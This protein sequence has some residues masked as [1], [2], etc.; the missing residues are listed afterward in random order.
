MRRY[1]VNIEEISNGWIVE[2]EGNVVVAGENQS[3]MFFTERPDAV[4]YAIKWL[5]EHK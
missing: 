2:V 4:E 3:P 1:S 5:K